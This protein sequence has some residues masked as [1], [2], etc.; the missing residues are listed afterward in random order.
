MHDAFGNEAPAARGKPVNRK[1]LRSGEAIG[2]DGQIVSRSRALAGYHSE[3]DFPPHL[4]PDGFSAQWVRTT[5]HGKPDNANYNH[6][7]SQGWRP[8]PS[9]IFASAFPDI[10]DG[11]R[12][13]RDG[14]ILMLRPTTLNDEALAEQ[15]ASALELRQVQSE[16]FGHRKLAKG[17]EEGRVSGDGRFNASRKVNRE[18]YYKAPAEAKPQLQY[19]TPGDDD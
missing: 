10:A 19:A 18:G 13:E 9:K 17:F 6:H 14:L 2:I 12:I 11:D 8:A 15:H 4:I 3:F 16:A 1:P 5:C 7:Y